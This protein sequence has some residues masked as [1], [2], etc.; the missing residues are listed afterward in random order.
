[1]VLGP[2]QEAEGV[3]ARWVAQVHS[4][5][6]ETTRLGSFKEPPVESAM[7]S[8]AMVAWKQA[9]AA[10]I[11]RAME[12]PLRLE[13]KLKQQAYTAYVRSLGV[14]RRHTGG[15]GP[16]RQERVQGGDDTKLPRQRQPSDI[17]VSQ[18]RRHSAGRLHPARPSSLKLKLGARAR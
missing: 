16:A 8:T 5:A 9:V 13:Q 10:W 11:P 14:G 7:D 15:D 3:T 1:M 4:K 12:P 18:P 6:Q 17:A 2:A